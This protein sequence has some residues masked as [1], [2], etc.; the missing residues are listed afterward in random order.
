MLRTIG[1]LLVV[2]L[3]FVAAVCIVALFPPLIT[4]KF[5]V[6]RT[7]VH[8]SRDPVVEKWKRRSARPGDAGRYVREKGRC[9]RGRH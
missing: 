6:A 8:R 4:Y 5:D 7:G 1:R 2:L 3:S 9:R